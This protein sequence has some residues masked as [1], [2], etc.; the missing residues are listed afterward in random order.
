[1]RRKQW[2]YQQGELPAGNC[3]QPV[4]RTAIDGAELARYVEA[5]GHR[6]RTETVQSRTETDFGEQL[7]TVAELRA[8]AELA[9]ARLADPKAM[10]DDMRQQRDRWETVAN[11]AL[12]ERSETGRAT[13]GNACAGKCGPG[14]SC[15]T[16]APR[17]ALDARDGMSCRCWLIA[18]PD[19]RR[20]GRSATTPQR[21]RQLHVAA[22]QAPVRTE[23]A[24][25]ANSR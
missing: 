9:E 2:H 13:T 18:R 15:L 1:L 25:P 5:N 12:A 14:A 7:A 16:P 10:L 17:L 11:P 4:A 22:L 20:R 19:D 23:R 8:R 24:T 3:R 21:Q 6:F